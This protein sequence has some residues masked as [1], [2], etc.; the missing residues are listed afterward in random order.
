MS[1][2][3]RP[4]PPAA[5]GAT[6]RPSSQRRFAQRAR[7]RRLS[8]LRPLLIGLLV[9][10]LLALAGWVVLGSTVLAVHRVTVSG[11]ARLGVGEITKAA[12]VP[13]DKPLALLDIAAV[14]R[15]VE[16]L[17]KVRSVTVERAWPTTVRIHVVERTAVAVVRRPGKPLALID[18]TGVLFADVSAAPAGMPVLSLGTPGVGDPATTAA[19][20][21]AGALPAKVR[22][23]VTVISAPTPASVTLSLTDGISVVWGDS[24]NSAR[25]A[26]ALAALQK[27]QAHLPVVTDKRGNVIPPRKVIGYDVSSPNVATVRYQ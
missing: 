12:A 16:T 17:P 26:Q 5:P 18:P 27:A 6:A 25:K 10:G 21:V 2:R 24:S 3:L 13:A 9:A 20:A 19:L 23:T 22:A 8:S 11:Q 4:R 7:R 14:R 1:L 15:R